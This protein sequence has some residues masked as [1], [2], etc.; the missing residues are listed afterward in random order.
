[1]KWFR[2][3]EFL[4]LCGCGMSVNQDLKNMLDLA[5]EHSGVPFKI[6]SAARCEAHNKSVGGSPTSS[7]LKGLAVDIHC[8]NP[9]TL[10]KI[11]YGLTQVGFKRFGISDKD[12]FIHADIDYNKQ[13][14]IWSY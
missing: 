9:L 2:E 14:A 3:E 11:I 7:H 6:N 13:P 1:M 5:R 4:C 12:N 10:A 8:D